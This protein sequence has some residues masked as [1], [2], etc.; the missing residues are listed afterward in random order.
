MSIRFIEHVAGSMGMRP[1]IEQLYRPGPASRFAWWPGIMVTVPWYQECSQKGEWPNLAGV[2][3]PTG[4]VLSVEHDSYGC[5]R[6]M[7]VMWD[8]EPNVTA[9]QFSRE[10]SGNG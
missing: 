10:N 3:L 5:T 4:V 1:P 6:R 2:H 9:A 8:G 7:L